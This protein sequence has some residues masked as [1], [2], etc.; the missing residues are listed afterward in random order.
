M[1]PTPPLPQGP[2]GNVLTKLN[3]TDPFILNWTNLMSFL[4][5]GCPADGTL[6]AVMAYMVRHA[7]TLLA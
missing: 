6:T 2:F 5:Q 3:V 7:V 4:L 1:L